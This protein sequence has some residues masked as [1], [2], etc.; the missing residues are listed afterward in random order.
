MDETDPDE[1]IAATGRPIAAS[2]SSTPA[3]SSPPDELVAELGERIL[4]E[5]DAGQT[6]NTLTR[7]LAHHIARLINVA[8][9][10]RTVGAPDA[11]ARA[12]EARTAILQLWQHRSDWPNGWPPPRAASI[13]ELLDLLPDPDDP[14]WQQQTRLS[15]LHDLHHRILATICDLA[16]ADGDNLE[17]GWLDKF[18]EILT[19]NEVA[20]L[21]RAATAPQRLDY[22]V[23]RWIESED[24][25]I[26]ASQLTDDDQPADARSHPL[27]A[28]ADAYRDAIVNLFRGDTPTSNGTSH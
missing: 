2:T 22:M 10:A 18:G 27:I 13:V 16:S 20:M 14:S 19:P 26:E 23:D 17:Q 8:D 7:W 9:H 4:A 12:A 6:N 28:L 5:F 25:E 3:E 1:S 15:R 21:T 24:E 11:D